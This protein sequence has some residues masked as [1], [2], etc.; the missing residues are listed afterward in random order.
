MSDEATGTPTEGTGQSASDPIGT[1][2]NA[3]RPTA[4]GQP[5]ATQQTTV[6]GTATDEDTFF[7]PKELDPALIPAYKSMQKA[8][9]KKTEA[10]KAQRQKIDAYDTYMKDPVW[11]I[12]RQAAQMGY[13]VSRAEVED[14]FQNT[15][16]APAGQWEPQTWNEVLMR[17]E[18]NVMKRLSPALTAV[19]GELQNLKRS[20][21]EKILD[22][23]APDWRQY[24]DE[25]L[26][27]L[28]DHPSLA[29]DPVKLYRISLPP[30]I[31]ETRAM[32][33]ALR[34]LQQKAESAKVGGTSTTKQT[35]AQMPDRH[36][37]F[38][39]AVEHAKT[40]LAEQGLKAPR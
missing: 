22:E 1:T 11:F 19:D 4:A 26:Q 10:L 5:Q 28:K 29:K 35:T 9:S 24:E 23:S 16:Q 32:Q 6:T 7:D 37:T 15:N 13:K 38:N 8:W 2:N 36:M 30:E 18:E 27:N 25:M 33:A 39:E 20:S 34:K 31:M 12:Q 3:P 14:S 17:A 21:I 40:Q